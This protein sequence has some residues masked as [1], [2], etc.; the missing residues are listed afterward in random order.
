MA[1]TNPTIVLHLP[2][3]EV[4]GY[5][6]KG[7][8]AVDAPFELVVRAAIDLAEAAPDVDALIGG[9]ATLVLQP[10]DGPQLSVAGI[11]VSCLARTTPRAHEL[12]ITLGPKVSA[13]AQG[14][15]STVL[16][17][18]KAPDVIKKVLE[19]HGVRTVV[20]VTGSYA[21][22]P[23]WLQHR[24]SDWAFAERIAAQAGI[25]Y[26][27]DPSDSETP[28]TL[29]DDS[30]AAAD[31]EGDP[32]LYRPDPGITPGAGVAFAIEIEE[33]ATTGKIVVRDYTPEKPQVSL[34]S[35][36]GSG[37][38]ARYEW[39]L[40]FSEGAAAKQAAERRAQ[41]LSST[42]RRVRGSVS[43]F[44]PIPGRAFTI[45]EHPHPALGSKLFCLA[46]EIHAVERQVQGATNM[47]RIAFEARPLA[48]P[49]R[50]RP[51]APPPV[52]PMPACV[53]GASGEE[54]LVDKAGRI[55]AQLWSD[56]DGKK[57]EHAS[58][59]MRVAQPLMENSMVT[60]RIGWEVLVAPELGLPERPMV[61]GSLY[62][63]QRPPPYALPSQRTITSWRTATSPD[64]GKFHEMKF[65]D[66]AG[67]ELVH[68]HSAKDGKIAV[69]DQKQLRIG[70]DHEHEVGGGQKLH[71]KENASLEIK[72]DQS[73]T[74]GADEKL[75]VKNDRTI[76]VRGKET[77]RVDSNRNQALQKGIDVDVDGD[78]KLTVGAAM[79][80]ESQAGISYEVLDAFQG[81]VGGAYMAKAAKGMDVVVGKDARTTIGAARLVKAE[82]GW[83]L[84][85][86]GK[87]SETIG[88][89][90]VF[91]AL[92]D[93]SEASEKAFAATIGGALVGSAPVIE[94][95]AEEE[96]VILVGGSSLTLKKNEIELKSVAIASPAPMIVEKGSK[97]QHNP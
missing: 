5:E 93:A 34:E 17:E 36:F 88:A 1:A 66:K 82:K 58:T 49:H 74:V 24:E 40:G 65:E 87:L 39:A 59:P 72:E 10:K 89:A 55:R 91:D 84:D 44:G 14:L 68:F 61:L 6:A 25:Y 31:A 51:L 8:L 27:F 63:A 15:D 70:H 20:S 97:V 35:T 29:G 23:H 46:L 32:F 26:F 96:L 21:V 33:R 95:I 48:D 16:V 22:A 85:I 67:S 60:P 2:S 13:V 7:R 47:V 73:F 83:S 53:V 30:T 56:R 92:G 37:E 62:D 80:L 75:T 18:M 45:E 9:D 42:G 81:T 3:G 28:L 19:R 41:A 69:D 90:C 86:E 12:V 78:R 11:V 94:I 38:D 43:T 4:V 50:P 57:D 76:D 54:I 64:N 79:K 52:G 71:V 77:G